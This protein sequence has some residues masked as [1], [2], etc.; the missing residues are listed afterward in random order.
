MCNRQE[1]LSSYLLFKLIQQSTEIDREDLKL[2][3]KNLRNA[4][5]HND[6]IIDFDFT[7][8]GD[9]IYS[10]KFNEIIDFGLSADILKERKGSV[11]YSLKQSGQEYIHQMPNE[12]SEILTPQFIEL[13]NSLIRDVLR[14]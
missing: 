12:F 13:S 14:D 10:N 6:Y 3:M 8:N 7:Q 11:I 4:I 5:A 9:N 2:R 1:I